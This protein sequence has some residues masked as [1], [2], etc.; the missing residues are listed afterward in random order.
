MEL[1]LAD[2]VKARQ[3]TSEG[4]WG[5]VER[6]EGDPEVNCQE[7]LLAEAYEAAREAARPA[8]PRQDAPVEPEASV[9]ALAS[10]E[11]S[12][13]SD[14]QAAPVSHNGERAGRVS[15]ALSLFGE[16]IKTLFGRS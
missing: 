12:E 9:P 16:G 1:Q 6:A 11:K 15:R 4:T 10:V 13:V 5:R 8:R 14:A 7:V 3:L 2:N